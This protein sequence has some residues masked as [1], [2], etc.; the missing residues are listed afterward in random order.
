[1]GKASPFLSVGSVLLWYGSNIGIV[2]LNKALISL[3]GFKFPILLTFLHMLSVMFWSE[4]M[5]AAGCLHR[6]K[7]HPNQRIAI[8]LLSTLFCVSVVSGN[9]SF[10][11]IPVSFAQ[12]IG[13]TTPVFTAF[14]GILFLSRYEST[15]TYLTLVPVVLGAVIA[16]LHEPSFSMIGLLCTI[17]AAWTRAARSVIQE[18][19]MSQDTHKLDS[20]NT[21]RFM[22]PIAALELGLSTY[23]ME[24]QGVP[25]VLELLRTDGQFCLLLAINLVLAYFVNLGGMMVTNYNGAL[26]LQVLGNMKGAVATFVSILIFRNPVSLMGIFGYGLCILGVWAFGHSIRQHKALKAAQAKALKEPSTPEV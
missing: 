3:Y 23:V 24:P 10:K 14:L 17:N 7:L 9:L 15:K 8:G 21:L 19:L 2:C 26:T 16:T 22:A 12:A 25:T 4:V 11:F 18:M 6:Q 5:A 20:L 1:M 13:A